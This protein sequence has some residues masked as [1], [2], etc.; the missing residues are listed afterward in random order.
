MISG[1][2]LPCTQT[3][4]PQ[5]VL[6]TFAVHLCTCLATAMCFPSYCHVNLNTA[7][8]NCLGW[9]AS[10]PAHRLFSSRDMSI[11]LPHTGTAHGYSS[12]PVPLSPS[13]SRS[14]FP[15]CCPFILRRGTQFFTWLAQAVPSGFL[16]PHCHQEIFS[17]PIAPL[18]AM[19]WFLWRNMSANSWLHLILAGLSW[20]TGQGKASYLPLDVYNSDI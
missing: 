15:Q 13:S 7:M 9:T 17:S 5:T 10:L 16:Q 3:C 4:Q 19:L 12:A 18:W 20:G 11:S 8:A 6:C 14:Q 2:L 1:D